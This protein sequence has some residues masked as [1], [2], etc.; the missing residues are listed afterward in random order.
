M[1]ELFVDKI[2]FFKFISMSDKLRLHQ[3]KIITSTSSKV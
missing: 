2:H 3:L 1:Q